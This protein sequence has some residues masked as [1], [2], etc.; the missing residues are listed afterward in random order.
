MIDV[1]NF[2]VLYLNSTNPKVEIKSNH[3]FVLNGGLFA[4]QLT[5]E[6]VEFIKNNKLDSVNIIPLLPIGLDRD[7]EN[8]GDHLAEIIKHIIFKDQSCVDKL[9]VVTTDSTYLS[10]ARLSIEE[11]SRV[12]TST[13]KRFPIPEDS[14]F[15]QDI[16]S[17]N[18]VIS[19]GDN[20]SWWIEPSYEE[21]P[22]ETYI[23]EPRHADDPENDPLDPTK[24]DR[25]VFDENGNKRYTY[26]VIIHKWT[27]NIR[28]TY[29]KPAG[30]F[31]NSIA[32][33]TDSISAFYYE[34]GALVPDIVPGQ[35]GGGSDV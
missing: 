6:V 15:A 32:I 35:E 29:S 4:Y 10:A 23:F 26:E 27:L 18:S 22:D 5:K 34:K 24:H 20:E 9:I 25:E 19:V 30:D 33:G 1:E 7:S 31:F 8:F 17:F 13:S 21:I 16:T 11:N 14:L 3:F 12:I 28:K 2:N